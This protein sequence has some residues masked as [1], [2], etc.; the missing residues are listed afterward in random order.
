M[1]H[2]VEGF[3]AFAQRYWDV[4]RSA[5]AV[6]RELDSPER[7]DDERAFLPAHLELIETPVSPTLRWTMRI[8]V[9]FFCVALLWAC[10]GKLDIVAVAPGRTVVDSRTKVIQPAET[11]VVRRILVRDGQ[12][13]KAGEALIELDATTTGAELAQVGETLTEARLASLRLT[14]LATAIDSG[15]SPHLAPAPDVPAGRFAAEQALASSQ[16]EALQAKRHNLQAAIAQRRA[17]LR[18]TR[19]AIE[20]MAESARISKARAEDYGRL[21]EGKYVGRHDYL[22]REQERIAAERDLATQRNRMQEIGSALSAAEEELRV[23]VA[24]FRQQTLDQLREAE[25]KVAQGT[26]ELAKAG[27]RDGLMTLRAPVDG[28]VQQLAVHTVGG[29]VTPAQELLAVVPQEALE[30]EATV[31]NKDIGFVRPGQPVTVKIESFPYTRYGYL[32]GKVVS[33]SHDA[34]QDEKLGLVFP[35]RIRLDGS[36]LDIDG[37]VVSMSAGMTLSAEIKTGKRRVIDYLLSP[38]RQH[39]GEALRER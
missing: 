20:P 39:G 4:L 8:I 19:D 9:A 28:T 33:V 30:V 16:F 36:K 14:A 29:V 26:P 38:L 10:L 2:V 13:V 11:A 25:Q 15:T 23:L 3:G 6:R 5:W 35:A 17:E 34:A 31:L 18:T 37:V 21:V 12:Q 22:L 1:K 24:D 7:S 27:R 32:T